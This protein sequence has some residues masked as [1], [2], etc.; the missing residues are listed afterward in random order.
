[1][2]F[3]TLDMQKEMPVPPKLKQNHLGWIPHRCMFQYLR[4]P[5]KHQKA[6]PV[7]GPPKKAVPL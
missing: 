7:P 1:M 6:M 4:L 5:R 3:G 2:G